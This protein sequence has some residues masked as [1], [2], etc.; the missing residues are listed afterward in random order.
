M[1]I[2]K[3]KSNYEQEETQKYEGVYTPEE[4]RLNM[5]LMDECTKENI[6]FV[7]VE[8]LLKQ[9]ADPL[10]GTALFGWDLFNHVYADAVGNSQ[11]N[12]SVLKY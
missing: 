12:N 8:E 6:D 2:Y 4:I 11:D 3:Y 10:G 7:K 5:K 1:S 9:G